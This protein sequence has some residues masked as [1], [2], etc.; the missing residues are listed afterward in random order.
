[1]TNNWLDV[2][3]IG[4]TLG[5]NYTKQDLRSST[6]DYVKKALKQFN[7]IH[8]PTSRQD[9]PSSYVAPK[10]GS[11]HPQMTNIATSAPMTR[12]QKLLL[13]RIVGKFLYYARATDETMGHG[14][15][16]LS[17]KSEGIEKTKIAQ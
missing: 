12:K 14:L 10:F 9:S 15:N 2:K 17:T 13:Q 7:Y 16:D 8:S 5:W 1:M 3:Y 11:R 6:P 4:I